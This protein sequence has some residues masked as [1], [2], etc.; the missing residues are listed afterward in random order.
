MSR[1]R[2]ITAAKGRRYVKSKGVNVINA[3]I[4]IV[5]VLEDAGGLQTSTA[6]YS[7]VFSEPTLLAPT[8]LIET[9]S[10]YNPTFL[11]PTLLEPVFLTSG[12]VVYDPE[13]GSVTAIAAALLATS[14]TVF[15]P[16]YVPSPT[17]IIVASLGIS[18]ST[19]YEPIYAEV[20]GIDAQL[21]KKVIAVSQDSFST[22]GKQTYSSTVVTST[23][24][25]GSFVRIT[26][27]RAADQSS[28]DIVS[29]N[30]NIKE[31][32]SR[33]VPNE[34]ARIISQLNAA[35]VLRKTPEEGARLI[36]LL[37]LTGII[38]GTPIALNTETKNAII[39]TTYTP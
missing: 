4:N 32:M 19:L 17:P 12:V 21:G 29:N 39:Y 1:F 38:V 7:M 15:A 34:A 11:E 18:I 6:V 16:S 24:P 9:L 3:Q 2:Q 26:T 20:I 8:F 25:I 28:T 36:T 27:T 22:R 35:S 33:G 37:D 14:S 5:R 23:V 31:G 10:L 13:Y 30:I